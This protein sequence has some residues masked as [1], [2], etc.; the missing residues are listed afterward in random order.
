[1]AAFTGRMAAAALLGSCAVLLAAAAWGC[2][3][4]ALWIALIP[5]LGPAGAPL[6][7]AGV[8]LLLAGIL[9][10]IAWLLVRRRRARPADGLQLDAMLSEAGRVINEHKGAALLAAALAG[11]LAANNGRKR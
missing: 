8:C 2:A 3:S 6:A 4:A 7:V 5:S 11:M 9:G 10:L 1:M